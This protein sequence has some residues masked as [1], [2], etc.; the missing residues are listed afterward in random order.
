MRRGAARRG[1]GLRA[2]GQRAGDG[3]HRG[4]RGPLSHRVLRQPQR[5]LC[6]AA[7]GAVPPRERVHGLR[8]CLPAV[9]Q[10]YHA[11]AAGREPAGGYHLR[12]SRRNGG[13]R[14]PAPQRAFLLAARVRQAAEDLHRLYLRAARGAGGGDRARTRRHRRSGATRHPCRQREGRRRV[15]LSHALAR[16]ARGAGRDDVRHGGRAGRPCAQKARGAEGERPHRPALRHRQR[17]VLS[18]L[19]GNTHPRP[20]QKHRLC[21]LHRLRYTLS[22]TALWRGGARGDLLPRG[23][24]SAP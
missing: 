21:H 6:G 11:G 24:V 1:A 12:L 20:A 18:E 23:G 15:A 22:R 3:A 2:G 8:P 7:A 13:Q 17:R 4:Q 5:L 10:K 19:H 9:Q 14:V 16:D